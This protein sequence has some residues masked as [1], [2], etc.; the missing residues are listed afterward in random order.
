ML[1]PARQARKRLGN[2][3]KS[4]ALDA[5]QSYL[6]DYHEVVK[7]VEGAWILD[8]KQLE[9]PHSGRTSCWTSSPSWGTTWTRPASWW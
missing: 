1:A 6:E 9:A 2:V 7:D 3:A 4:V 5:L 8:E